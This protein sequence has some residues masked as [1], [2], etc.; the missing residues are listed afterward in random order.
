MNFLRRIFSGSGGRVERGLVL[1]VQPRACKEVIRVRIDTHND[2]SEA[3]EGGYYVR[4]LA[5]GSDYKCMREV[6]IE[7]YFN[8]NR[9]L[10]RVVVTGGTQMDEAAYDAW[11]ASQPSEGSS[12]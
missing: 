3:D 2:L 9:H 4:K 8:N 7:V 10:S 12:T 6:E 1:Y 11:L 5:R